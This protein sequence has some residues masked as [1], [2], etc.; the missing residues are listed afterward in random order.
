MGAEHTLFLFPLSPSLVPLSLSLNIQT[1]LGSRIETAA[2][3]AAVSWSYNTHT[4]TQEKRPDPPPLHLPLS[5]YSSLS[6]PPPSLS[7]LSAR[8]VA[9]RLTLCWENARRIRSAAVLAPTVS[10]VATPLSIAALAVV[11]VRR[12]SDSASSAA[13][14]I[15]EGECKQR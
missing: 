4:H 13:R 7:G 10:T 9:P 6:R 14:L 8:C 11:T 12:H 1:S 2:Y 5:R 3:R 15:V